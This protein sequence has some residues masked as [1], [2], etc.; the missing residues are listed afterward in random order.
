VSVRAGMSWLR[1]Q[2]RELPVVLAAML[3]G[4]VL[5]GAFGGA[6]GLV[7][8]LYAYPPTAWFAVLEVGVPAGVVGC[9]LGL[10]AGVVAHWMGAAPS[11]RPPAGPP[12]DDDFAGTPHGW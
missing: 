6:V 5:L 1:T 4:S 7:V 2:L 12:V 10:F 11:C 9:F 8:G 3:V